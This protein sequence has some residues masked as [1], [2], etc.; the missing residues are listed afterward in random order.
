MADISEKYEA[1]I[2][3]EL[4]AQLLTGT[5]AFCGCK[6]QI[7]DHP[8]SQV[9]PICLGHPGAL[10]VMNKR[11]VEMAVMMG[12]ATGCSIRNVSTF[13]RKN[14]F[15]PDLSKGYQIT[16][17]DD[18]ICYKGSVEIELEEGQVKR[19]GITRIHMEEDAGKSLHDI[20]ID[21]LVDFNR[22]GVPLI[23]IVSEPDI[24]SAAEAYKYM[25]AMRQILVYLNICDGNLEEGSLRC[26]ANVSVRLKGQEK[27]GVKT[28]IKNLNSFRNVEKAI[29]YEITRHI[30]V[31]EAG[32]RIDQMTLQW[33]AAAQ[34]TKPMRSKELA[35][36]YRYFPEPDLGYIVIDKH[37]L[38]TA[39][40]SLPE[41]PLAKKRRLMEQYGIPAYD[42]A[43]LIEDQMMAAFF[44]E[45]CSL[46]KQPGKEGY[47]HVSNWILTEVLKILSE[48]KLRIMQATFIQPVAIA[49]LADLF[50]GG[51]ISSKIAKEAF[52]AYI[53]TGI[54]P[55]EYIKE[56]G[57]V[58]VSDIG[59]VEKFVDEALLGEEENIEKYRS[60]RKNLLGYFISKVMKGSGGKAN[61]RLVNELLN[62]KLS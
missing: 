58:Q 53:S 60:G 23:E 32:G 11:Q 25:Q 29:K 39:Q 22:A 7:S 51:S 16:Q 36:D 46:L 56:K 27:F 38:D 13:A 35:H 37:D 44:E 19:I 5:K 1:V 33:D 61:P 15:Y 8:N 54:M 42:A 28:E 20:D 10:P 43:I 45:T 21:T 4:H 26:D 41:L 34:M 31:I 57:L 17:F 59:E 9:C 30:E 12:L 24:R 3:L 55:E 52:A 47:K 18:P 50:A 49:N 48:K 2:G 14:Y 40:A 6:T 62:K